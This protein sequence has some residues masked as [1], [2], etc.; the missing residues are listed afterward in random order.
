MIEIFCKKELNG[1]DGKFMLEADLSFKNGDFVALYGA[2]GGG[3]TTILRLIAG[4]EAPQSGFIR[5]GDKVFFDEKT[6]LAPQKRNIGFLFQDYALFE[7]MNVFK[8]LLFAKN[9]LNLANKLLDIC[10]L[11]SLKNAK[12]STL[13][14]GQKQRVALARAVMRK[15]EILLLDEPLSA[16][17]NAMREKLQDYLLALHDEFKM[18]IILVSHDIAEIYKLCNKVF[19]LEN[20]KISRSG[21]ASEIFLK[22]A[23][24]QK[25]AF[26]AKILEIKKRDAIYVANVLINRQICE[27]VLSS[28]E[29]INLKAGDMVVVSTKAFS[30]NLEKA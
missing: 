28:S 6:N 30:V 27:V 4:F 25:F 24:S 23:G 12:I 19:V 1:G 26:N 16:L 18:S 21:S 20:G 15:P 13:S 2:S 5:V 22:S 8:N 11:T 17:D 7:N 3:K 14:G 10:G 29:A 9:D